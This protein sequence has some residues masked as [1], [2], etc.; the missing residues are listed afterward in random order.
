MA[1]DI[2]KLRREIDGCEAIKSKT[3]GHPRLAPD[4]A[5]RGSFTTPGV[6]VF[7][8]GGCNGPATNDTRKK[9]ACSG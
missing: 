5:D 4:R 9:A 7:L 2:F 3:I 6:A 8:H 1:L